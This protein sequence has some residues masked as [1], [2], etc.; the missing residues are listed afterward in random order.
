MISCGG[1]QRG[2]PG[3]AGKKS[4]TAEVALSNSAFI[5]AGKGD[6]L[7]ILAEFEVGDAAFGLK[8]R[9]SD[10]GQRDIS[11]SYDDNLLEVAGAKF[12]KLLPRK[13]LKLRLPGQ[14]GDGSFANNRACFTESSSR[15]KRLGRWGVCN[16]AKSGWSLE[17]QPLRSIW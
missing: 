13:T 15:R 3:T 11:I 14:V 17:A 6:A 5:D 8:V 7:E 12:R 1:N 4:K 2:T 16:G 10:D 9:R